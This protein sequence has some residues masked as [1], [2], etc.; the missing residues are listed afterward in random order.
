MLFR[1]L[2]PA[3]IDEQDPFL[4]DASLDMFDAANAPPYS[5]QFLARF[6]AAQLARNERITDWA[7]AQLERIREFSNGQ[8]RDLPDRTG[9]AQSPAKE[10]GLTV[11]SENHILWILRL[12]RDSD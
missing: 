4:R 1:S 2:D 7:L 6:R 9:I 8:I 3:I 10:A 11:F 5:A 12:S